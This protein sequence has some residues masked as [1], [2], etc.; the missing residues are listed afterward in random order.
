MGR[1]FR[2]SPLLVGALLLGALAGC[3]GSLSIHL[4]DD[5]AADAGVPE[6]GLPEAG[7]RACGAIGGDGTYVTAPYP[8]LDAYCLVTNDHGDLRYADGVLPY[9]LNTPLFSDYAVKRRGV[10]LPPGT[11]A[12]Y[13]PNGT[14]EFPLGTILVKSFGFPDDAR[15]AAPAMRWVETRLL[16]R[17]DGGWKAYAYIWNDAQ[18]VATYNPGGRGLT[19]SWI[20]AAGTPQNN[21]YLQPSQTQCQQCHESNG[22]IVPIGPKARNL[23]RDYAYA[24]GP[25]NQLTRWTKAGILKGAPADPTTVTRLPVWNDATNYTVEQ[26]ARAYLEVNCAHCHDGAGSGSTSGLFL[27]V[28]ETDPLRYGVCKESLSAGGSVGA[29]Q[30]DVVPGNP[31][32]SIL[33]YRMASVKPGLAMP[34]IGRDVVDAEAVALV[35]DWILGL[36]PGPCNK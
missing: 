24:D 1:A 28:T 26:R 21:E 17:I 16:V 34:Q 14:F 31:D 22:I 4:P 19:V 27:W 6:A 33:W 36:P 13:D 3:E 20:D 5:T 23:N 15:K 9:D 35:R 29:R 7:T 30:W 2:K 11:S 32:Q 8:T 12:T 10:F 18:T 25:A